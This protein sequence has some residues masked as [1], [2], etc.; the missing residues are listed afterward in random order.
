MEK[1]EDGVT[2]V[3][4]SILMAFLRRFLSEYGNMPLPPYIYESSWR[5]RPRY[6]TVYAKE[7]GSAAAPTAGTALHAG[8][9]GEDP[10]RWASISSRFCCMWAL[11]TFR[12]VKV[13][14]VEK[15]TMHS[16]YYSVSPEAAKAINETRTNGGRVIAVGTTSVRTLESASRDDGMLEAK[17]GDTSI[18][19]YPGYRF[20]CVD[21]LITNFH[22]PESTLIMLVSALIGR[23]ETLG[24]YKKAVEEK[25]RVFSFGDAMLVV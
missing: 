13:E 4:N 22:L 2:R 11:G 3:R 18:F 9:V 25:Y 19:I 8:A 12:P 15:H 6:Q 16:E 21:C 7:Q 20:E 23:E 14:D 24:L 10:G 1:K 17:S 5:I